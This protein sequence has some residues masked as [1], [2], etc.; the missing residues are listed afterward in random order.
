[1][2]VQMWELKSHLCQVTPFP[3]AVAAFPGGGPPGSC[4]CQL[5]KPV[6]RRLIAVRNVF[7]PV[8]SHSF[9]PFCIAAGM[10]AGVI[11]CG[12]FAAFSAAIDYYLR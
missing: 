9:P 11:G 2:L 1:M 3:W 7:S 8:L 12:G 5:F 10:K 6:Q 4:R